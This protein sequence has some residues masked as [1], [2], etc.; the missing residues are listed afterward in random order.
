MGDELEVVIDATTYSLVVPPRS[1][2]ELVV[3]ERKKLLGH[4]DLKTLVEDLSR[5]GKCIR[6]ASNGVTA[7]GPKFTELQIEIQDLGY[8][9]TKLCDK[10]A[11]TVSSST[12]V[13][14]P[15]HYRPAATYEYLLDNLEDVAL[16]TLASVSKLAG[17]MGRSS[18]RAPRS[19]DNQAN[20]VRKWPKRRRCRRATSTTCPDQT[21]RRGA[22]EE[23]R[24]SRMT[25][26]KDA[27]RAELDAERAVREYEMKEDEALRHSVTTEY[28]GAPYQRLTSS[29]LVH[30]LGVTEGE[31]EE[32]EHWK[33]KKI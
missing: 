10:S 16:D 32:S 14:V 9:V 28:S 4:I 25:S 1:D 27:R 18:Q 26:V 17:Q 31:G 19:V 3:A 12:N 7:A 22:T 33:K 2:T 29:Y 21:E 30:V 15:D 11:I 23:K 6:V 5:V 20:K 24:S 8:D 13:P